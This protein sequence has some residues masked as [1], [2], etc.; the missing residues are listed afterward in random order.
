MSKNRKADPDFP[1]SESSQ[2]NSNRSFPAFRAIRLAD[3]KE[4]FVSE[5]TKFSRVFR[6]FHYSR[7]HCRRAIF[8]FFISS[9]FTFSRFPRLFIII[10]FSWKVYFGR[11]RV[12]L[13]T[14]TFFSGLIRFFRIF[15][16]GHSNATFDRRKGHFSYGD[17]LLNFFSL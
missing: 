9:R 10:L 13:P 3:D 16:G 14:C 5:S 8:L 6:Y 11:A 17:L 2:E 7:R 12:R 15:R 1:V 4:S